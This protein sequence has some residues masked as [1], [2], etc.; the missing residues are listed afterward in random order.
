MNLHLSD[1]NPCVNKDCQRDLTGEEHGGDF[2][3]VAEVSMLEHV[4][5][6]ARREILGDVCKLYLTGCLD[7]RDRTTFLSEEFPLSFWDGI[8]SWTSVTFALWWTSLAWD[9]QHRQDNVEARRRW[10]QQKHADTKFF[11]TYS[12]RDHRSIDGLP[13]YE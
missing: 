12:Q 4:R 6:P 2:L 5:E 1:L 8:L 11:D 7:T 10:R 13:G 3:I 9:K